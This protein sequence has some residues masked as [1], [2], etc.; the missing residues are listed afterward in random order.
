MEAV[1]PMKIVTFIV[2]MVLLWGL[3]NLAQANCDLAND[4]C[5]LPWP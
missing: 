3:L 2:S 1:Q 4:I 5:T